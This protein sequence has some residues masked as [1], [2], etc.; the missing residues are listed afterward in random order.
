[1]AAT[2]PQQEH[3]HAIV[4]DAATVEE[5]EDDNEPMPDVV[6]AVRFVF[7]W[8]SSHLCVAGEFFRW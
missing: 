7:L 5:T 3:V 6:V 2:A 4:V 1:M 8:L